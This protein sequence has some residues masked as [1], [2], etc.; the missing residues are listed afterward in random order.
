MTG[1]EGGWQH[2]DILSSNPSIN[3]VPHLSMHLE[4]IRKIDMKTAFT[5]SHCLLINYHVNSE[6]NLSTLI[7]FG[8]RAIQ[9]IRLA[10]IIK[11]KNGITLNMAKNAT[12]MPFLVAAEL[13]QGQEFLCP[14]LGEIVPRLEKEA[15][16]DSYVSYKNK[17]LQIGL[18]G[19][20]PDFILTRDGTIEGY[21]I[22]LIEML[23]QK[24]NF[25][26]QVRI[27]K[28]LEA[29]ESQVRLKLYVKFQH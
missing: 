29:A 20:M 8:W 5:S 4:K 22:R 16:K 2:C 26:P 12:K 19:V 28:S 13:D 17:R 25:I 10:I 15:C 18:V 14:V 21:V 9:H 24:F 1:H 23:A 3:G 11:M 6:D 7:D 27:P